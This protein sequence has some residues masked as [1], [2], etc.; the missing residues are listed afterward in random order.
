[1]KCDAHHKLYFS[2]PK[3]PHLLSHECCVARA[4][5]L[6]ILVGSELWWVVKIKS[7]QRGKT[8]LVSLENELVEPPG[9]GSMAA[10]TTLELCLAVSSASFP[11][12]F[13]FT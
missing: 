6:P 10:E 12:P 9:P 1:M 8:S 7:K 4:W 2:D 13:P 3:V 5:A 11:D